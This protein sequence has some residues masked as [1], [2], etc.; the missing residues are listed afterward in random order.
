MKGSR[1]IRFIKEKHGTYS[2]NCDTFPCRGRKRIEL[3]RPKMCIIIGL[4]FYSEDLFLIFTGHP[5]CLYK[6]IV[7]RLLQLTLAEGSLEVTTK[8]KKWPKSSSGSG[9]KEQER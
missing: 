3:K 7:S 9:R 8:P 1:W 4:I 5:H 6:N 2:K